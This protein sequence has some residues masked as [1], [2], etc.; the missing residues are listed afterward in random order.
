MRLFTGIRIPGEIK[1]KIAEVSRKLEKKIKEARIVVPENLHI[2]LKF[3]GEI[4]EERIPSI[5]DI[6]KDIAKDCA[7]FM[8][9]VR[10]AGVFPDERNPRVFWIGCESCGRLKKLNALIENRLEPEGFTRE[11]RFKEHITIARFKSTPKIAFI[12]EIIGIYR[13]EVFGVMNIDAIELI[14]SDL[15]RFGPS[16][17]T[18]RFMQL[19]KHRFCD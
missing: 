11:N 13:D 14:R 8:T 18:M 10:G 15:S 3:L 9:E 17:T 12:S 19:E 7:P 6:L 4:P 5:A 2:T 16:Y 1:G